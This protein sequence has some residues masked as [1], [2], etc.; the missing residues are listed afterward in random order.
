MES[1]LVCEKFKPT[2]EPTFEP[3][4]EPNLVPSDVLESGPAPKE[5]PNQSR[6]MIQARSE[7][8]SS[9]DPL[10][11]GEGGGGLPKALTSCM[12]VFHCTADL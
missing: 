4:L 7:A 8:S 3:T 5:G 9:Q 2:F 6:P 1:D 12:Y 10:R 11:E